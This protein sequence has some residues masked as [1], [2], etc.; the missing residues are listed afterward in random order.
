MWLK[1]LPFSFWENG[2]LA[3][4]SNFP[5]VYKWYYHDLNE[6]LSDLKSFEF[7]LSTNLYPVQLK[8]HEGGVLL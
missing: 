5:K 1:L 6:G 2:S 3:K 7:H 8:F 4:V